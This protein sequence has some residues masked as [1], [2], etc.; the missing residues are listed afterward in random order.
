MLQLFP[1]NIFYFRLY[2]KPNTVRRSILNFK[3]F[4]IIKV[5]RDENVWVHPDVGLYLND[6]KRSKLK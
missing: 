1:F 3:V 2:K 5:V 6:L 4:H